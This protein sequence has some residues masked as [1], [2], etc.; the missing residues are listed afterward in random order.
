MKFLKMAALAAV[1]AAGPAHATTLTFEGQFNTIYNAPIVRSGFTIGNPAGDEQHFHEITSTE[2]GL[3]NNGTGILLNDRDTRIFV[4]DVALATFTLGSVD[5]GASTNNS[6]AVSL[7]IFGFL[8][9]VQTG[10]ITIA[11]LGAGYTTVNG[12]ALGTIDRLVFDGTGGG[13]GFVLDNLTLNGPG[14]GVVPEPSAWAL[15][16]LGFGA[17]GAGMRRRSTRVNLAFG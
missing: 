9:N 1:C 14:V 6:P 16:I 3:P 7:N 15:L 13:G 11:S 8:N 2:F 12:A 4:T 10:M 17:V 5:V